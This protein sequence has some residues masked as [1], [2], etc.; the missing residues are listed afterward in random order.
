MAAGRGLDLWAFTLVTP[1]AVYPPPTIGHIRLQLWSD[2]AYGARGLQYFTFATPGGTDFV[3]GSGLVDKDGRPGPAYSLAR[4]AN[5]EIRRVESLILRWKSVAV[6]HSEPLPEGTRGLTGEGP[7]FSATG[8]P[9]VIGI[10]SDGPERYVVCVNRDY[11]R[12]RTAVIG[13]SPDVRQ[14]LEVVKNDRP[15]VRIVWPVSQTER[16]SV[17]E[18]EPGGARIFRLK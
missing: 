9:L 6:C 18:F 4:E 14:A 11:E 10:F 7:V 2:I 12:A 16:I 13:F 3:W 17:L 1:H 8:A 5:A 15:P